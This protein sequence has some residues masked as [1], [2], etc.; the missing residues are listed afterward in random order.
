PEQDLKKSANPKRDDR[1]KKSAARRKKNQELSSGP[2]LRFHFIGDSC[3]KSKKEMLDS[4][5]S[6]FI[7]IW[8]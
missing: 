6:S 3:S 5:C 8:E 2:E 7:K 1:K 4:I